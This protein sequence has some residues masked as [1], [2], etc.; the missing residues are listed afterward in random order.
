M[1]ELMVEEQKAAKAEKERLQ[2][3]ER[4]KMSKEIGS[5]FKKGFFGGGSDKK[6]VKKPTT[7]AS[8]T[9]DNTQK[10]DEISAEGAVVAYQIL[11]AIM[12]GLSS[13]TVSTSVAVSALTSVDRLASILTGV[14]NPIS[15]IVITD[16]MSATR[17]QL[18]D[19]YSSY[20][21]ASMVAG[22][23]AS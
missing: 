12:S 21:S 4:A 1:L 18:I 6:T 2:E 9:T 11:G 17:Y 15:A 10:P 19:L 16:E 5:G 22:Q 3:K 13:T 23:D 20:A 14:T 8:T 7:A